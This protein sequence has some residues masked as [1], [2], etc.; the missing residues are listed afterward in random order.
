MS[1]R[2]EIRAKAQAAEAR[3]KAAEKGTSEF[4]NAK[5]AFINELGKMLGQD[6]PLSWLR[7]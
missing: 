2:N 4:R 6:M 1:Y 3:L 7:Y 5:A